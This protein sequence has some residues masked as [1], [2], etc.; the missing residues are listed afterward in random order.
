MSVAS[1]RPVFG[2]ANVGKDTCGTQLED[3]LLQ[4]SKDRPPTEARERRESGPLARS[5]SRSHSVASPHTYGRES[6]GPRTA[7]LFVQAEELRLGRR[8]RPDR[9]P[10]RS[11]RD[12]PPR[13]WPS[14]VPVG[15]S[16]AEKWPCRHHER[17]RRCLH[18]F[19]ALSPSTS[20]GQQLCSTIKSTRWEKEK[21][22]GHT[23]VVV[24]LR[25]VVRCVMVVGCWL[26]VVVFKRGHRVL[27]NFARGAL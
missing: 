5:P 24:L 7:G 3:H 12:P 1:C 8:M 20:M 25:V 9:R 19:A 27:A 18:R 16:G 21:K 17:K 10:C 13:S 26:L 11:S 22:H 15:L 14:S 4:H 23:P 6:L 2:T